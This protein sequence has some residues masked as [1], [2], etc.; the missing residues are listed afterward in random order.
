MSELGIQKNDLFSVALHRVGR[1]GHD[2]RSMVQGLAL[3]DPLRRLQ[4]P[5]VTPSHP[6]ETENRQDLV[7][8]FSP[9]LSFQ[10]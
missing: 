7:T 4:R 10:N 1:H 2:G 8:D 6:N 9:T 3:P 5:R